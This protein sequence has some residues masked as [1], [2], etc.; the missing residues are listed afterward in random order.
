MARRHSISTTP[1]AG[2]LLCRSAAWRM[3]LALVVLT[4]LWLAV[5]WA[6]ALP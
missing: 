2:S 5:L 6:V 3:G 4:P 1:L